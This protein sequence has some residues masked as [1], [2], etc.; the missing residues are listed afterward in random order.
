MLGGWTDLIAVINEWEQ[1]INGVKVVWEEW[2]NE[3]NNARGV[4]CYERL[5][6]EG[7]SGN[8]VFDPLSTGIT[9]AVLDKAAVDK[10][11]LVTSSY[12]RTEA[13]HGRVCPYVFPML[14]T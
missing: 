7:S 4:E 10:I 9:Y 1:G 8:I 14:T 13:A 3:Y 6:T 2:E 11:P 12:G 5:K